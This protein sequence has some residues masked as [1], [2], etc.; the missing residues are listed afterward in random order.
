MGVGSYI[1]LYTSVLSWQI[2]GVIWDGITS[3]GIVF[4]PF[5]MLIMGAAVEASNKITNFATEEAANDGGVSRIISTLL[6]RLILAFLIL[7]FFCIPT[8]NLELS[9]MSYQ[10]RPTSINTNPETVNPSNDTTTLSDSFTSLADDAELPIGWNFIARVASGFT[11]GIAYSLPRPVDLEESLSHLSSSNITDPEL[12]RQIPAFYHD[13]FKPA[14][15][16]LSDWSLSKN[17]PASIKSEIATNGSSDLHYIGSLTLLNTNGLYKA[18]NNPDDCGDSLTASKPVQG[19][20]YSAARDS[21]YSEADIA[22]GVPGKPYCDEWWGRLKTRILAEESEAAETTMEWLKDAFGISSTEE[23]ER[24]RVQRV[25]QNTAT[26]SQQVLGT[27]VG[28]QFSDAHA[29]QDDA[30]VASG[31]GILYKVASPVSK[32]AG[33]LAVGEVATTGFNAYQQWRKMS[34]IKKAIPAIIGVLL[35]VIPIILPLV[36]LWKLYSIEAVVVVGIT[37]FSIRFLSALFEMG[38]LLENALQK[39]VFGD[40]SDLAGFVMNNGLIDSA[41]ALLVMAFL[42]PVVFF[43][44]PLIFLYLAGA[45]GLEAGRGVGRAATDATGSI[46]ASVG[47]GMRL[48]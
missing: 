44:M 19:F 4:V 38:A 2:Y 47:R 20:P 41:E 32:V 25:L 30:I 24:L 45:M 42:L 11:F 23:I 37:Y 16:K 28:A 5:L 34:Y 35:F 36:M 8:V 12:A 6:I 22:N 21:D 18:C 15:A 3:T 13:C 39:S 40:F 9:T 26:R 17:L 14:K 43:I 10:P 1:E 7:L 48:K 29:F 33:A 27:E 46:G 31:A